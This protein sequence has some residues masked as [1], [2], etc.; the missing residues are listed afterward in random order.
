MEQNERRT[1]AEEDEYERRL[2]LGQHTQVVADLLGAV[3]TEPLSER[4]SLLLMLAL[5]RCGRQ[6]GALREHQ[7]FREA[8]NEVGLEP[9]AET[10]ELERSILLE[11][12]ELDWAA[13]D[14]TV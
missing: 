2:R 13:P 12:P 6:V 11:L 10:V 7:R 9:S 4:R 1:S 8:I 3:E 14:S 5:Y